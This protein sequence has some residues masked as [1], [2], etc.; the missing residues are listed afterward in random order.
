M[1]GRDGKRH[2]EAARP[3]HVCFV[4]GVLQ[5]PTVSSVI[6]GAKRVD[7]L[8][9]NLGSVSVTFTADELAA[10]DAACGLPA[11]YPGWMID[12]W[13]ASRAAQLQNSHT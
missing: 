7:Q 6:V 12:M 11:E 5:R 13:S 4:A 9:D 10:L 8:S 2:R 1:A 3:D